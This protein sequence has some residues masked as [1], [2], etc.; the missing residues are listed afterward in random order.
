M[1]R[2]AGTVSVTSV[3][4]FGAGGGFGI[5]PPVPITRGLVVGGISSRPRAV[6]GGVEIRD[7]LD[8]TVTIDHRLVDGAPA[9]RSGGAGESAELLRDRPQPATT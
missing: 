2:L 7:V 1:R 5:A 8:L 6:Y 9:A 4:M 3:G